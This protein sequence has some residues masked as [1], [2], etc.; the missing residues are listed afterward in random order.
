MHGHAPP[1]FGSRAATATSE[2]LFGKRFFE[3]AAVDPTIRQIR[4]A[5][6]RF[7]DFARTHPHRVT[8]ADD[9]TRF[10]HECRC[11]DGVQG[12]NASQPG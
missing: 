3:A 7:L 8:A 11:A 4:D 2:T 1:R 10:Q 6:S 5:R 12:K 9:A